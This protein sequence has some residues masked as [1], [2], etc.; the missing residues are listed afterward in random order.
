MLQSLI[1]SKKEY[2]EHLQDLLA[3]PI[4]EKIYNIYVECQ[5]QGLRQFQNELNKIPK[6]NNYTIEQETL[7]IIEKTSCN[8]FQKLL[9]TVIITSLKIKFYSHL[10]KLKKLDIQIPSF[11]DF[12]H[13]CYVNTSIFA[14]KHIYLFSQNNLK[15]VEIQNNIN[16]LEYNVHKIIGKTVLQCIDMNEVLNLIESCVEKKHKSKR[17]KSKSI[18]ESSSESESIQNQEQ[19]TVKESESDQD[20]EEIVQEPEETHSS[21]NDLVDDQTNCEE[22]EEHEETTENFGQEEDQIEVNENEE[23]KEKYEFQNE[24]SEESRSE[25]P[26]SLSSVESE[27]KVVNIHSPQPVIKGKRP[28]FF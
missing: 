18:K 12:V 16:V 10:K 4:S 8:Y 14:W 2:I 26:C 7:H 13:K 5:K 27:I 11:Q 1:D 24:S 9:K 3:T 21:E 22:D 23:Q 15:H 17:N 6:W 25:S 19:E 20:I 28:A